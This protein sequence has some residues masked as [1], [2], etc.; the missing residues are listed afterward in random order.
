MKQSF[1]ESFLE[2]KEREFSISEHCVCVEAIFPK[3]QIDKYEQKFKE[4]IEFLDRLEN[5]GFS[6]TRHLWAGDKNKK[7]RR[8]IGW[9]L[10]STARGGSGVEALNEAMV[11]LQNDVKVPEVFGAKLLE[12]TC[13]TTLIFDFESYSPVG[14]LVI[15]AKVAL[16]PSLVKKLGEPKLAGLEIRFDGSPVGLFAVEIR[17]SIEGKL[18]LRVVHKYKI[19]TAKNLLSRSFDQSRKLS[20]LFVVKKR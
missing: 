15:P 5:L 9:S 11:V 20:K 1:G 6:F 4:K 12:G 7:G 16:R 19:S 17:E 8:R 13:C 10:N 18:E 3:D 2:K 14:E